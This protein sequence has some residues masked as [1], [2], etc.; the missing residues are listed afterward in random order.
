MDTV[1]VFAPELRKI[2]RKDV[3]LIPGG[4]VEFLDD[5]TMSSLTKAQD[6]TKTNNIDEMMSIL[7]DQISDWNFSDAKGV[8][9]PITL[10]GIKSLPMKLV[11]WLIN[12]QT[13][14]IKPPELE[15]KKKELPNN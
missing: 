15:D 4:W 9:I 13:E 1:N 10:Q 7:V 8:T 3:S 11:T 6:G 12:T 5:I 14:I 2:I